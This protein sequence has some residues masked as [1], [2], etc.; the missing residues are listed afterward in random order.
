MAQLVLVLESLVG[1][2]EDSEVRC[3]PGRQ[4]TISKVLS[5]KIKRCFDF[6]LVNN[7]GCSRINAGAY[8]YSRPHSST[9]RRYGS[10]SSR[11][12]VSIAIREK[13]MTVRKVCRDSWSSR[14][15]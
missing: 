12:G 7:L 13:E 14:A 15:S 9:A 8:S 5:A 4:N 6:M 2:N 3:N 10:P 1:S 11:R